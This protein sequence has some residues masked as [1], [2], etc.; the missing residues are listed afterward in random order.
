MTGERKYQVDTEENRA[1]LKA[2]GEEL[3]CFER[4]FPSP[5]GASYYLG[6]DGTPWTDR[7]RETWIT[8]RMTHVYS[9]WGMVLCQEKVQIKRELFS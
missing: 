4:K 2:M 8:S 5:G 6:G 3:L 1:F 9:I 7:P